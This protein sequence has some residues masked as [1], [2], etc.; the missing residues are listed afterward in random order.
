[1]YKLSNDETKGF[2]GMSARKILRQRLLIEELI[3][4]RRSDDAERFVEVFRRSTID[5]NPHQVEAAMFA[6]RRLKD[7]G[8]ML[9]DEVVL[10]KT[11]AREAICQAIESFQL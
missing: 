6:L 9:C 4:K 8:A 11:I 1:M 2:D 5:P 10:G 3:R 7:G